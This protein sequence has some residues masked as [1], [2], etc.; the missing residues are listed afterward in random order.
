MGRVPILEN[1]SVKVGGETVVSKTEED[2]SKHHSKP[3][4]SK[5]NIHPIPKIDGIPVVKTDGKLR[6]GIHIPDEKMYVT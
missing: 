4:P 6:N 2:S 1:S 5:S 3:G